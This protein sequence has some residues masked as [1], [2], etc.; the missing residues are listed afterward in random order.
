MR[1]YRFQLE[2]ELDLIAPDN[3][4]QKQI[5]AAKADDATTFQRKLLE[6]LAE[7]GLDLSTDAGADAFTLRLLKNGLRLNVKQGLV[8]L[9]ESTGL[10]ARVAPVSVPV[11]EYIIPET[12]EDDVGE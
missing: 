11:S 7:E 1:T 2:I 12:K 4:V 9:A 3:F 10:G 5:E 6:Q 8:D